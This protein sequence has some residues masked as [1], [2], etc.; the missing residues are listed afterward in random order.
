MQQVMRNPL[1]PHIRRCRALAYLVHRRF[2]HAHPLLLDQM[3][4]LGILGH[5]IEQFINHTGCGLLCHAAAL[6]FF[7]PSTVSPPVNGLHRSEAHFVQTHPQWIER[8]PMPV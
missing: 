5:V 8:C 2:S 1:D 7:R 6:L 3:A 4:H